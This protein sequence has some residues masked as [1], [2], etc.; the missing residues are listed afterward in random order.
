MRRHARG[1]ART[2]ADPKLAGSG[3]DPT[4]GADLAWPR[5]DTQAPAVRA[6][7]NPCP[8]RHPDRMT[9]QNLVAVPARALNHFRSKPATGPFQPLSGSP[10]YAADPGGN[11][12]GGWLDRLARRCL[13]SSATCSPPAE[14]R[15]LPPPLARLRTFRHQPRG[16]SP[17]LA[18]NVFV[19]SGSGS[20]R[21]IAR[22]WKVWKKRKEIFCV[23]VANRS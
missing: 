21:S 22:G 6:R 18:R 7:E 19:P 1:V 3:Q 12:T 8:D 13:A 11:F 16:A 17:R 20:K 4:D 23:G 9:A 10:R 5:T 15:W 14:P 2:R